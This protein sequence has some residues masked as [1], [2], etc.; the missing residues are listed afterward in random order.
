MK[1]RHG[2]SKLVLYVVTTCLLLAGQAICQESDDSDP[3]ATTKEGLLKR[4]FTGAE[5]NPSAE[6]DS[7]PGDEPSQR[8]SAEAGTKPQAKADAR[9]P[10]DDLF[11]YAGVLYGKRFFD[12]ALDKYRLYLST[13]PDG[14]HAE[15]A[16]YRKAECHLKT[17]SPDR[18]I[19][20]YKALIKSFPTSTYT[21]PAAYRIASQAYNKEDYT[22][23]NPYFGI[24]AEH[25]EIEKLKIAS[26]YYQARC[27]E[28]TKQHDQAKEIYTAILSKYPESEMYPKAALSLGNISSSDKKFEEALNY[29]EMVTSF[30]PSDENVQRQVERDLETT[31][32]CLYQKALCLRKLDR[33]DEAT[34]LLQTLVV[35]PT[36]DDEWKKKAQAALR[37]TS[38]HPQ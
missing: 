20:D 5:A 6:A 31:R 15:V 17:G 10:G 25:A 38:P 28:L 9:E 24:A 22:E 2:R 27:L 16:L 21:S 36:R 23:A 19:T 7:A 3:P 13:Y 18:A 30:K 26:F 29:F 11:D 35:E 34:K 1:T 32:E 12:L 4:L 8:L 33:N 37:P 14:R